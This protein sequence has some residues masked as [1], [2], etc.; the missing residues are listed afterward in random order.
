MVFQRFWDNESLP[1]N[2]A[3]RYATA[4]TIGPAA[5]AGTY[6]VKVGVVGPNW[7]TLYTWN[8]QAARI[9]VT[10]AA[11]PTPTAAPA[12]T[13]TPTATS[14]SASPSQPSV[15]AGASVSSASMT[16]GSSVAITV[17]AASATALAAQ[18]DLEVYN[19]AGQQVFQ[20]FWDHQSFA[21]GVRQTYQAWW[22]IDQAAAAGTYTVKVGVMAPSWG[23]LYAWNN[24]AALVSIAAQPAGSAPP[25]ATGAPATATPTVVAPTQPAA[26]ASSVAVPRLVFGLG[27]EAPEALASPL[28]KDAP[29]RMLT[30]WYNKPEDLTWLSSW[31]T[32][33]VPQAYAGDYALHLIVYAPDDAPG[34]AATQFWTRHGLACGRPYPLS[35]RFLGDMRQLAQIFAG[36]AAGPPLYVT[37]FTEVQ[38][39]GC[40][41]GAWNPDPQTNAY[42]RALKERYL[43]T[44]ALFH[45]NA[46][47]A[48]VSLGW[49]G[50]QAR[51]DDPATGAG[52]SMF[53]YFADVMAA[54]DFQ[55]FQAMQ[56]DT[57]AQDVLAM[58]RTLGQYGPVLLAH[59]RPDRYPPDWASQAVFAADMRAMLTDTFLSQATAAGLFGWSFMDDVYLRNSAESYGLVRDGI[60]RFG[61]RSSA[62]T[63]PAP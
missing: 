30:N 56:L 5:A 15:S 43:E 2:A 34:T 35:D 3:Q 25:S 32:G 10:A 9:G 39:Y 44:L 6:T 59:Y 61:V 17:W 21:A 11:T 33:Q 47:N 27:P 38:T 36:Q 62:T 20:Q 49:G 19:P 58:T 51:Y 45:Q 29:L 26:T 13:A 48:K 53:Q 16:A 40:G 63:R 1:A 24:Q 42:Y 18:V 4:W 52:R 54:S 50:W 7:G 60:R 8:N 12:K 22:T 55:S 14:V 41:G 46:P 23:A 31:K 28:S 57:N 37:L